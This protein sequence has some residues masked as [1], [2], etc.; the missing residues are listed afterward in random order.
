M[1]PGRRAAR[2][3]AARRRLRRRRAAR[4]T[5]L[6]ARG[7]RPAASTERAA[8]TR[9]TAIDVLVAGPMMRHIVTHLATIDD[10]QFERVKAM[11]LSLGEVLV[12]PLA[13]ALS[14]E[15]RAR[16]RERLT[17]ILIAFGAVGRRDGR[18]AEEL[19]ERGRPADGHL[20]AARVRRQRR[21]ARA[22]RAARRQRAAGAARGGARD[23]QHR[24]RRGVPG[25]RSRRSPAARDDRA[26]R[27]CSR[28]ARVRD[29]RAAPLFAYILRHVDHRGPLAA[30]YLRAIEALGALRDPEGVAPLKEALVPRRVVGA[31]AH[32]RSC[33]RPR[34]RRSRASARRRRVAVLDEAAPQRPA[35][36]P[37]GGRAPHADR[38][39]RAPAPSGR[40]AHDRTARS[41]SPTSSS[42]ASRRRSDRRSSTRGAIPIIARN[43]EALVGRRSAA[44]QPRARRSS[45]ASS[46]TKSSS[47]TCRCAKARRPRA[48]DP[49]PAADRRRAHHHRPRRH[50]RRDLR[51]SSTRS[52][53]LEPRRRRRAGAVPDAAAH[54]RRPRHRRA[55]GRRPASADMATIKR[56]YNDAVSVGRDD[57]GQRAAPKGKPDA[58][59]ARDD[60]RRPRAGGRRR[61]GRRCSR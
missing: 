4:S 36:R 26:T 43:L 16:P 11:C 20:P 35:R 25:A 18:A 39:R 40:R 59:V 51:P 6:V 61:T 7:G 33:A 21:A 12:R 56:L 42:A 22:D 32:A 28:S 29:E 60:D 41:S 30:V 19:A 9:V 17:A 55:A 54:P 14:A 58:T 44:A 37:R 50:A 38:A 27:S 10:A 23:P 57:L 31:A 45:S 3:S 1:T 48:A 53:T 46:A 5:S 47:T 2:G 34:P 52:T 24:H 13:E 8:S 49:A 15:E